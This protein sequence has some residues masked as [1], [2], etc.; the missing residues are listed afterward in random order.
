M[1]VWCVCRQ[2]V[3]GRVGEWESDRERRESECEG[4][5]ETKERGRER[6]KVKTA[7]G[8]GPSTREKNNNIPN[9]CVSTLSCFD[10]IIESGETI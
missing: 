10:N 4:L 6:D 2:W 7:A 3:S 9:L 1:R 8:E 5:R